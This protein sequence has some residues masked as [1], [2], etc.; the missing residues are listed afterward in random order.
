M[1][2]PVS[3]FYV[4]TSQELEQFPPYEEL[5]DDSDTGYYICADFRFPPSTHRFFNDFGLLPVKRQVSFDELSPF[6]Q[7]LH[8]RLGKLGANPEAWKSN[9]KLICDVNDRIEYYCHYRHLKL[10]KKLGVLVSRPHQVIRF[11]QKEVFSEFLTKCF[12]ARGATDD[13]FKRY[14][15]KLSMVSCF[16]KTIQK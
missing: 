4:L 16:G 15:Y 10:A 9:E 8:R 7:D 2:L 3:D 1:R 11:K 13:E 5:E 12:N 6:S 14:L